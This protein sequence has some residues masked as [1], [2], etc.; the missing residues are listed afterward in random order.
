MGT[1]RPL[2][3]PKRFGKNAEDT[4]RS[5]N[6]YVL[7]FLLPLGS[8]MPFGHQGRLSGF[9]EGFLLCEA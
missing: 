4:V 2:P 7:V 6:V 5:S 1:D 9:F 3:I 8:C